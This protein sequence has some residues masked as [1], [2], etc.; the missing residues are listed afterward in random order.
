[1]DNIKF[2]KN[3]TRSHKNLLDT[4]RAFS[5]AAA[6]PISIVR[7]PIRNSGLEVLRE[8][9][10]NSPLSTQL[11]L[12]HTELKILRKLRQFHNKKNN[13]RIERILIE[14]R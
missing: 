1:M 5:G 3:F 14:L 4:V 12:I 11:K 13:E 9:V 2:S 6:T 10:S 7:T 8:N